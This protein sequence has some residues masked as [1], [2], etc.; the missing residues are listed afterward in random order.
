MKKRFLISI[1]NSITSLGF[2]LSEAVT[3]INKYSPLD[4]IN[5]E[6][7]QLDVL[8]GI[9]VKLFLANAF[10]GIIN[11]KKNNKLIFF[12]FI[13]QKGDCIIYSLLGN[14]NINYLAQVSQY[15]FFALVLT[16]VCL[17]SLPELNRSHKNLESICF[18]RSRAFT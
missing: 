13:K 14:N 1:K 3:S 11:K 16:N 12:I 4:S 5:V 15:T 2:E 6:S 9:I 10:I 7:P 18:S 17:E 8:I